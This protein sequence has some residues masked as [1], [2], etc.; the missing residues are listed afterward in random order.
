MSVDLVGDVVADGHHL[1]SPHSLSKM[2]GDV[3][4]VGGFQNIS[5]RHL[6]LPFQLP[7]NGDNIIYKSVSKSCRSFSKLDTFSGG[8]AGRRRSVGI[9]EL[10]PSSREAFKV[11]GL[12]KVARGFGI[13]LHHSDRGVG[14][15]EII[16]VDEHKVRVIDR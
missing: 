4:W 13:P 1:F 5:E 3:V 15:P 8:R 7:L 2:R 6:I 14:P 9:G 12:V 10:H 16:N 11:R